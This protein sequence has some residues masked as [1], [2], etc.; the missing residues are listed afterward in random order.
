MVW[1]CLRWGLK[2]TKL[3]REQ[4][5][6]VYHKYSLERVKGYTLTSG[7]L[8]SVAVSR[9]YGNTMKISSLHYR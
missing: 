4:T 7:T 2:D 5:G 8:T 9:E 1:G 3:Y 6:C